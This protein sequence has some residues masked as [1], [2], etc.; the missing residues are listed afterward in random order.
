M[1][2]FSDIANAIG[3]TV[4]SLAQD[5]GA[6]VN[7][8]EG[9]VNELSGNGIDVFSAAAK[10]GLAP[11]NFLRGIV[12]LMRGDPHQQL[13]RYLTA[14]VKPM[15]DP[16]HLITQQWAQMSSLHQH[17]AQTINAHIQELFQGSGAHAYRS[18][19]AD[20]LWKTNQNYQHYSTLLVDHAQT[21]QTRYASLSGY[22][23]DYLSQAPGK[24][25]SLSMPIAALGL[26]SI[27]TVAPPPPTIPAWEVDAEKGLEKALVGTAEGG[28]A[29]FPEDIPLWA[30]IVGAI[31]VLALLVV[32]IV[33]I[34]WLQGGF[35]NHQKQQSSTNTPKPTPAPT[36]G[37]TP[38]PGGL[39]P[40]QQQEVK[41]IIADATGEGLAVDQSDV[42]ALVRAGYDRATILMML[43][44]AS[45]KN[46]EGKTYITSNGYTYTG[47]TLSH[48]GVSKTV[49]E[50]QASTNNKNGGKNLAT[51]FPDAAT[52][53][54]AVYFAVAHSTTLQNF[55]RAAVPNSSIQEKICDSSQNFG[56]GYQRNVHP[57]GTID[58]PTFL[59]H[60][61]CVR[62]W[63]AVDASGN[64]F[65]VDAF[66]TIA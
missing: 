49:L 47:H 20:V 39:T 42:E 35:D 12:S 26:L 38:T 17:T 1:S 46:S 30:W 61:H 13:L 37:L 8:L 51:S 24:V 56:Y 53:Q 27:N 10:L 62:V 4:D 5:V 48:V 33:L 57:N 64:V 58:P 29:G 41:D 44:T 32:I 2:L 31:I 23:N 40:I 7:M 34:I 15:D 28:A 18:P 65:V 22:V 6:D 50:G 25:Y 9:V 43:R 11:V 66:P 55:I 16:L 19:A 14:P 21:Q 52:A 45:V 54:A 59:P 60:L 63:L 36:P 3:H